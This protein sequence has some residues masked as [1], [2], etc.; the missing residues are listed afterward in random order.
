MGDSYRRKQLAELEANLARLC[1]LLNL[2]PNCR[3]TRHFERFLSETKNLLA[4]GFCQRELNELSG[5]VMHVYGG[6]GSFNDYV[7]VMNTRESSRW[8]GEFGDPSNIIGA[9]FQSAQEL[10]VVGS[11]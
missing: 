2:D 8:Y 6:M 10:R 3:W 1:Q 9:V 11:Y 5:S 4:E 7:P